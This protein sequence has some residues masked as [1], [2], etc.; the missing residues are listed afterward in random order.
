[1]P[2]KPNVS[3]LPVPYHT[4]DGRE[5]GVKTNLLRIQGMRQAKTGKKTSLMEIAAEILAKAKA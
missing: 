1:M 2:N 3:Y 4:E 5:N